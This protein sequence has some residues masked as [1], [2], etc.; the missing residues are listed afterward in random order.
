[1][2]NRKFLLVGFFAMNIANCAFAG[3]GG[4][5]GG[6]TEITQLLNNGQLMKQVIESAKTTYELEIQTAMQIKQLWHDIQNMKKL[7][8]NFADDNIRVLEN[9]VNSLK[10]VNKYSSQLYGELT[11]LANEFKT[12]QVEAI[13]SKLS[14]SE[15]LKQQKKLID[16][17]N[18]EATIRLENEKR[19]IKSIEQDFEMINKWSKQIPL[20]EG[21]QQ[22]MGLLNNQMSYAVQQLSRVSELLNQQNDNIAKSEELTQKNEAQ[23]RNQQLHDELKNANDE[24]ADQMKRFKESLKR[25]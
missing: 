15:Y 14:I 5:T 19:L 24:N 9:E 4:M 18:G 1:M 2:L 25:K 22:S 6:A 12:R 13:K 8:E 17:R 7:G 11:Q 3:G 20:N 16:N 10:N 21:V 23:I